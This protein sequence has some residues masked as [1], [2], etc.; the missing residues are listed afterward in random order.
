MR[1]GLRKIKEGMA[2]HVILAIANPYKPYILRV[3]ASGYA[4]GG[5][6]ITV[7]WRGTGAPLRFL[8]PKAFWEARDGPTGVVRPR[9]GNLCYRPS[10]AGCCGCGGS[11]PDLSL[12]ENPWIMNV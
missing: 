4:V 1:E 2:E 11:R 5:S 9:T 12:D 6:F 10:P 8:F 7:G 3:D